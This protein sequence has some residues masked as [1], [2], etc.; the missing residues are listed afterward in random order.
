[1]GPGN[2][3]HPLLILIIGILYALCLFQTRSLNYEGLINQ[4]KSII[5]EQ[6]GF[7]MELLSKTHNRTVHDESKNEK[8]Q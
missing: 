8:V 3:L 7:I 6:G 5:N 1:M 4:I 2:P